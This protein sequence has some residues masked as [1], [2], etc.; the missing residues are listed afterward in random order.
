MRIPN[1]ESNDQPYDQPKRIT[2]MVPKCFPKRE[3][4]HEAKL[5]A[6]LEPKRLAQLEPEHKPKRVTDHVPQQRPFAVSEQAAVF[7]ADAVTNTR[8]GLP[9]LP[10]LRQN[11]FEYFR[12][13]VLS[14][15]ERRVASVLQR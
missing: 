12:G 8:I 4:F 9:Q 10:V 15:I 2:L 7:V 13:A 6:Q 3:P 5:L 11:G 1:L 14:P